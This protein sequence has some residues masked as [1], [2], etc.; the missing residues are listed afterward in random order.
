MIEKAA[1]SDADAVMLDLEDAVPAEGKPSARAVVADALRTRDW[2]GKI[3]VFRINA[4]DTVWAYRDLIEVIETAGAFVDAVMV[5]KVSRPED[6]AFVDILLGQIESALRMDRRIGIEAQIESAPGLLN[7]ERIAFASPRLEALVFGPGDYSA[8]MRMPL[9]AIGALD[10]WDDAYPGHRWHYAMQRIVAAA[11]A[12]G[13]RAQDGPLADYTD[14]EGLRRVARIARAMGFDGKWCIHPS[15]IAI[16]NEV[17]SPTARELAWAR[18][19]VE[20][21]ETAAGEG[22][23]VVTVEGTMIDMASVRM[24]RAALA[25]GTAD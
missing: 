24:A 3:R 1:A 20:A 12:A 15:Q 13:L 9:D 8:S 5:P 10:E 25:R 2:R 22:R 23:G 11:R 18:R 14:L 4:L 19:V 6:V 17:F 16:V 21:Y 7:V